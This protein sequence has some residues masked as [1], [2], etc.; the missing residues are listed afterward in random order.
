MKTISRL[1]II[2]ILMLTISSVVSI[3]LMAAFGDCPSCWVYRCNDLGGE[4]VCMIACM[5]YRAYYRLFVEVYR[6]DD[7][8]LRYVYDWHYVLLILG[9]SSNCDEGCYEYTSAYYLPNGWDGF[10]GEWYVD[11]LTGI[12][13]Q[14]AEFKPNP[15][16]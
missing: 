9:E 7:E 16:E 2:S 15:F 6:W 3:E 1:M 5:E 8:F 13:C 12:V 14:G 4:K 11:K 10:T